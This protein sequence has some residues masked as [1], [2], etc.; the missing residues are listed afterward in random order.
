MKTVR[1]L[2]FYAVALISLEVVLWGLIGLLRTIVDQ[3]VVGGADAL[4]QA[5]ALILVG[6]PIFLFHW[7]WTQRMA[8]RDDEERT[9]SLRAMFFYAALIGTLVPVVQ[10]LLALVNRLLLGAARLSAERAI[11]GGTQTWPDNLIA[12]AMNLLVAAYFW[13]ILRGEWKSLSTPENF[14]EVRRLYRYLWVLYSLLMAVFGAQQLL[15]FI[16]YIPTNAIKLFINTKLLLH[17]KNPCEI[18]SVIL[19]FIISRHDILN[20]LRSTYRITTAKGSRTERDMKIMTSN[21]VESSG[22]AESSQ[23]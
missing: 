6:V 20:Y 19:Q 22:S 9:S 2:Y 17:T 10:N 15:R 11:F 21:R 12:I 14:A 1:R 16:F 23:P 3:A 18:N 7:L 4:A 8:A 13:N 5:L